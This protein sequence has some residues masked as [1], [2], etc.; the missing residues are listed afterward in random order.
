MNLGTCPQPVAAFVFF[1][2][3][4]PPAVLSTFL[5]FLLALRQIFYARLFYRSLDLRNQGRLA[6]RRP[7]PVF[8]PHRR[9]LYSSLKKALG[10]KLRA[11]I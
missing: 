1:D 8:L 9:L 4:F 6:G 3:Q 7:P 5:R 10:R 2:E 11:A